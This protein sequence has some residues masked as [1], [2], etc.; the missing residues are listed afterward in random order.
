M[1][2]T[3]L[4]GTIAALM[5]GT[6]MAQTAG[7]N[8]ELLEKV[9]RLEAEVDY[10][11]ENA[12]AD[13]KDGAAKAVVLEGLSTTAA[14]FVW[15]GDFRYRH[16]DIQTEGNAGARERDRIRVRFGA[17]IKV[18]DNINAKIQ[19][20][21]TNSGADNARSTNQTMG[22]S[23]AGNA[24]W[25]RKPVG[26]DQAYVEWKPD[27]FT[28]VQLGKTPIPWATTVSYFWDKDLTPEGGAIKYANGPWF[29]SATYNWLSEQND[30]GSFLKSTDSKMASAQIGWKQLLNPTTTFTVAVGYFDLMSVKDQ[31]VSVSTTSTSTANLTTG[32][33]TTTTTTGCTNFGAAN[34]VF[35]SDGSLGNTTVSGT[36]LNSGCTLLNSD[37]NLIEAQAQL[38]FVAAAYPVSVFV[39]YV[40]NNG[41][42]ANP[43]TNTKLDTALAA[44]FT[45]NKASAAKSWEAG[46]V[47]Q[48]TEKD[49]VFGGFHDSDF[50]GGVTDTDGYA[51]KAAYVPVVGWTLNAT[52]LINKR[53]NDVKATNGTITTAKVDHDYKRLQLDLNYKF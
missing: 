52:Y 48:K 19:F 53:F 17:L 1:K 15:S 23:A 41:A 10:L 47:Y 9:E 2:K 20:S 28:T 33:V 12:K 29:A 21:T 42:V 32:A 34:P 50:G 31:P 7:G 27:M 13:R 6:A 25:D 36:G 14:K 49:S 39:D 51:L 43:T 24:A 44:G 40:K 37:F 8:A 5:A 38:D 46:V 3:V 18:A 11:K 30:K 16:E 4:A 22:N 35:S 45:F 26:F